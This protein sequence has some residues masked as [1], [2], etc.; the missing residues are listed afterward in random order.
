MEVRDKISKALSK[1]S[2][3]KNPHLEFSSR[4]EFGDYTTN[5]ALSKSVILREVHTESKNPL[6]VAKELVE[7]LKADSNLTEVVDKINIAGPGFINFH[8][9]TKVLYANLSQI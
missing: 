4:P 1:A 8:L 2:G 6:S 3:I 9:S 5:I 7:K